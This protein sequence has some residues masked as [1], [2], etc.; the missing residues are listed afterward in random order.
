M[1][2]REATPAEAVAIHQPVDGYETW[3]AILEDEGEPVGHLCLSRSMGQVFGHDTEVK[4]DDAHAAI[5]LWRFARAKAK[6][7][8]AEAVA[9]HF[10]DDTPD[11]IRQFWKD[12]GFEKVMEVYRGEI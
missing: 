7:W 4:S 8:G 2:V 11:R 1:T 10:D 9:V 5:R 6:E 12:R 3:V